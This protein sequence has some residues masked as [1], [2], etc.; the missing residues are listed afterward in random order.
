V[1]SEQ[2]ATAAVARRRTRLAAIV[3][4]YR[5]PDDTRL[6]ARS[7]LASRRPCDQIVIVDNDPIDERCRTLTEC[8]PGLTYLRTNENRGFSGGMN[9][10]IR[11][12]LSR[13]ADAVFLVN[14]DVIVPPDCIATLEQCL[15]ATV[16]GGV[17]GPVLRSRANPGRLASAGMT[18][19]PRSGRM[20]HL[21]FGMQ[22]ASGDVWPDRVVDGV[23]G[24][25]MLVR[26][27][28]FES[29]GLFD[30]DYFYSFEDLELCLKARQAG[31]AT[32][33]AG[34]ATAYHEGGRS[35]GI[36]SPRRLYFAAR[37][38]LLMA[39]RI[40]TSAAPFMVAYRHFSILALNLAHAMRS[41]GGSL[42]A[43][44][45]AVSRGACDYLRGRF[46]EDR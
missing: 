1:T 7:L 11:H 38:H 31:F 8:M 21:W 39:R 15:D 26:R 12:A 45:G 44:L 30:E 20:R 3:L 6:A 33:V 24:C 19:A 10:G 13:G 25:A 17:A 22:S 14:S 28:V 32:V 36:E 27:T 41:R 40:P 42:P 18:Y 34:A 5:T 4:N 37:N 16:N 29:V 23:S 46:G 2:E 9:A 35:I 43:R